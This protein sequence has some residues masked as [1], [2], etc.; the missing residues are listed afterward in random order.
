MTVTPEQLAALA[1]G[2]LGELEAA[3]I[4]REVAHDPALAR[5]LA[6][7][8]AL[9]AMLSA[10]YDPILA[11]PVPKLLTQPI[12][13]AAKVVDFGAVRAAR[14]RWFDQPAARYFAGPAIAAS[15]VI[16]L[17]VGRGGEPANQI[18][19]D[20]QIAASLDTALSGEVSA[21]GTKVLL[22]FRDSSG[23][24]CRAWSGKSS[25]GIACRDKTGWKIQQTGAAGKSQGGDYQQASSGDAELLAAAQEM[26]A[27][28]TFDRDQEQAARK[29]G[30]TAAE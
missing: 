13:D 4:R 9:S 5:Q 12:D 23:Q 14:K 21:G 25:G 7:L 27:G 15:V 29:A 3:R 24:A 22:S 2:E 18:Y 30:W 20:A 11:E 17:L 26:A 1:D 10:H 28:P 8:E 19:A 16:A 6:E